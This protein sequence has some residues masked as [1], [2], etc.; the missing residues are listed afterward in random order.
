MK[1]KVVFDVTKRKAITKMPWAAIVVKV[2][3]GYMGFES[4]AD[5][6]TWKNIKIKS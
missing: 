6:K 3:G 5:Y 4:I 2:D 1:I